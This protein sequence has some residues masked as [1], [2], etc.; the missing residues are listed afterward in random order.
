MSTPLP[1]PQPGYCTRED[2]K[3]ALDVAEPARNN[4]QIDRLIDGASRSIEG[5]LS[6]RFWPLHATITLDWPDEQM[7]RAWRKWLDQ[8]ELISADS[9]VNNGV[10]LGAGDYFLRPDWGPPYRLIEINLGG[11]AAFGGGPTYQ[12]VITVTGLFGYRD[13]ASPAGTLTAA[14]TDTTSTTVTLNNSAASG[15]GSL[16]RVDNERMFITEK[17]YVS[18]GQT[19]Q[20]PGLALSNGA[21]VMPVIDGTQFAHGEA[22]I[23]DGETVIITAITG[24]NLIVRRACEGS[25]LAAHTAGAVIYA[26]RQCTVT[27]GAAGSTAATHANSAP[28]TVWTPPGLIRQL[29]V[30]ETTVALIAESTGYA[31]HQAGL[32]TAAKV[33]FEKLTDL[34]DRA[35]TAFGRQLRVR[36]A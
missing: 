6:R 27:R 11:S 26:P 2:V 1:W 14:V 24:N 18:T 36:T 22:L 5:A 33:S 8:W 28:V 19:L 13:D 32:G 10:A 34:R 25:V 30:A 31:A 23:V 12:R 35:L 17:T 9:I 15:V 20:A 7:P 4:E 3:A 29:A 21:T 16:I